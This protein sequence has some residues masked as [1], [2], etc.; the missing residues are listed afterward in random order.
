MTTKEVA[1]K[2]VALMR[3]SKTEQIHEELFSPEIE[4]VEPKGM[5]NHFVKGMDAIK[6]KTKQWQDM[7][8]AVHSG[9][10]GE[11]IVADNHFACTMS[12][13]CTFKGAPGPTDMDE[14]CLYTVEHG[15]ITRESYF[16]KPELQPA[17]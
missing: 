11:P 9:E 14:I 17:Q 12:Y 15:K 8:E 1:E 13:S 4:S 3:E 6:E 7:V 10:V 2:F 5:P 16:Y